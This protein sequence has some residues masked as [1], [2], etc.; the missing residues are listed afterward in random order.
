[1]HHLTEHLK[2]LY[3]AHKIYPCGQSAKSHKQ[4]TALLR[5]SQAGAGEGQQLRVV[6]ERLTPPLVEKEAPFQNT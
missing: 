5:R 1:M 2:V 6:T 3:F 4:I